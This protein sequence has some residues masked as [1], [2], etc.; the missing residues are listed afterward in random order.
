MGRAKELSSESQERGW[1]APDKHVCAYCVE[2][3]FLKDCIKSNAQALVCDYCGHESDQ[4]VA[5]PVEAIMYP[6]GETFRANFTEPGEAGLPR[7]SGEWI[8]DPIETHEALDS[9][10]LQCHE[11]LLDDI[12]GS[13][14]NQGWVRCAKGHW[15]S[16][17]DST[18]WKWDW[19]NFERIVKT[20]TRYFFAG[21]V[22]EDAG[23][24]D[25]ISSP[26]DLLRLIGFI[27]QELELYK[28]LEAGV[29]LYRVREMRDGEVLN[30]F[31]QLGAPPSDKASAGRMNPSGISYLYLA[32]EQ[33]TVI[34]EVLNCPPCLAAIATFTPKNDLTILDLAALPEVPSIYEVAK[35]DSREAILF[36]NEFVNAINKPIPKDGREHVDYVPSQVVS[37]F[38]AQVFL[39]E[40]IGR[41]NGIVYPSAVVLGGQNVVIFPPKGSA[42]NWSEVI[43]LR[44]VEQIGVKNWDDFSAL[45]SV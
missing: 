29:R 8:L 44:G 11:N 21:T 28:T 35:Y 30:S 7:D 27:A 14:D 24:D 38:F 43:E 45:L 3:E 23:W 9:L 41:I 36:L 34:G 1:V 25:Q 32:R 26:S 40:E 39:E 17:H 6:I 4:P 16:E 5:A 15:L 37:E 22:L 31:D 12:A 20:S 2:D 10:P 33:R 19:E 42:N 13:F 18:T